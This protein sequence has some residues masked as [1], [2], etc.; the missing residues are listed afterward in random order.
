MKK[1]NVKINIALSMALGLCLVACDD[2]LDLEP[3]SQETTEV[4]YDNAGQIEAVLVGAYESFQSSDYYAWDKILFQDVRS[5]NHY[6]GGDNPEIFQLDWLTVTPTNSRLLTNWSNIYNAIA[7]ANV[8]LERAPLVE[9]PQLTEERRE[10][11]LGEAY[12]LRAYHY[13]TLVTT[14]GQVPLVTEFVKSTDPDVI[15]PEKSTEDEVYDQILSDLTMA[16]SMLPDTYGSDA[17]VNKARAT[18]GAANALAAKAALQRPTPDYQAALDYILAVESSSA[19]YTLIDYAD[20]FD[21]A[22]YNNA[23][24]ILEVQYIGAPEATWGPQMHLPPSISGDTWRKFTTPSH[25]LIDA[26]AA[27]GDVIRR[28]ATVLFESVNWVDEYWGNAVGSSIPFAYKWKH[29]DGWA[30]T[31]R[32]HLLRLGDVVLLKAEALTGLNRLGDAATEVNRIRSRV[33]LPNLTVADQASQAS[34][35]QAILD[36]RRLELAQEG[37][38][39]DDLVRFDQVVSVM[40][41]LVEIDLRTGQPVEYNMDESKIFVPIPQE[42]LDRNPN[43]TPN[44]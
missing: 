13:Y 31:D 44:E 23:E 35:R 38:R 27:E 37:Q 17:S 10:Q 7:K 11:I 26:Y 33:N 16:I 3:I 2:F 6:A 34:M 36:E 14:W 42:E 30:S 28:D 25:N 32:L 19:N 22:H 29:A 15:R 20:L 43:L 40:N 24:S 12:F 8:V 1:I 9:D 4:G 21:G 5:D 18:A 39:W 41:N